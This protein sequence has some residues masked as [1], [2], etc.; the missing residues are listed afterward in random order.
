M[1]VVTL[2]FSKSSVVK[3]FFRPLENEKLVFS[4]NYSGLKSVY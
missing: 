2:S 3:M 1:I 4:F